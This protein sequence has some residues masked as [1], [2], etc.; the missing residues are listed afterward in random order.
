MYLK[1]YYYINYARNTYLYLLSCFSC[2]I[3]D[4]VAFIFSLCLISSGETP[5]EEKKIYIHC[6]I[7]WIQY[8]QL[9]IYNNNDTWNIKYSTRKLKIVRPSWNLWFQQKVNMFIIF[10]SNL[11]QLSVS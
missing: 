9:P 5:E 11:A 3:R 8:Y 4:F 1:V 7:E 2:L 6:D 10:H